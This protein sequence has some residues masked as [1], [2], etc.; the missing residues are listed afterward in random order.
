MADQE[1]SG[2]GPFRYKKRR[3]L[4]FWRTIII[5]FSTL[6]FWLSFLLVLLLLSGAFAV[7]YFQFLSPKAQADRMINKA[8]DRFGQAIVM[9]IKELAFQEFRSVQDSL[10]K[11]RK[12]FDSREYDESV[13]FAEETLNTLEGAMDRLRSDEYFRKERAASMS[14]LKGAVEVKKSGSLDWEPAKKSMRLNKGDRIRTRSG[15]KTIVQFDDGSQLTIKSNS[16]VYIDDLSEDI[17]TRTKNSAIKLLESDVEAS[18]LRPTARGSRFMIETPGSV[19]QIRKARISIKVSKKNETEYRLM[20]GDVVVKAAGKDIRIQESDIV[21]LGKDGGV[22]SRGKLLA[23]P[24]TRTPKNLEWIV[25]GKRGV[26]VSFTWKKVN[27]ASG[28]HLVLGMDRYF[29]NTVYDNRKIKN[30]SARVTDL[31]PGLY[32]WKVSSLDRRSRESLFSPFNVFRILHDQRPPLFEMQD[33]IVLAGSSGARVY[34][35]GAAEPGTTLS[36]NG[37]RIALTSDGAFRTFL[38]VRPGEGEIRIRASDS[39][40]NILIRTKELQ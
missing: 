38:N 2:Q 21:R 37:K 8:E 10:F 29:T 26:P 24:T 19:A 35:S 4:F 20:S 30:N 34:I 27:K 9:G 12:A 40:G 36:L 22:L 15:A 39:A 5:P 3:G 14:F 13:V 1:G 32:Y 7:F 18:I 28:Y 33:P 17:R 11:A 23:V 25:S 31:K 16:L 6:Q